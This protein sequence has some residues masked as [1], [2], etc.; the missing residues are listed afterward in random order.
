MMVPIAVG[1]MAAV[2]RARWLWEAAQR[3]PEGS[4]RQDALE[5]IGGF[6]RRVEAFIRRSTLKAQAA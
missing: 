6:Q 1:M 2:S 5:Q 4:D 3:L